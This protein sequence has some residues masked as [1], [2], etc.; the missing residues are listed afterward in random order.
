VIFDTVELDNRLERW[1][2]WARGP[3]IGSATTAEGYLRERLD[4]AA[5]SDELTQEIML[6]EK[7]VARTKLERKEYWRVI[8]RYY[9]GRLSFIEIAL[10]YHVPEHGVKSLWMQARSRVG[11]HIATLERMN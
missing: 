1:A 6:T 3:P 4:T 9:L 11:D 10:F 8:A 7:A 5:D 2:A